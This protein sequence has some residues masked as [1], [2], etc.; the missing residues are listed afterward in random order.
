MSI[1]SDQLRKIWTHAPIDRCATYA[2]LLSDA[3]AKFEIDTPEEIVE[4][5]AQISHE[6]AEGRYT[7]EIA[8]GQAYEGRKDLGNTQPGD[9]VRYKGRGL[10]QCTGRTNYL[11]MG[12]LLDLDLIA[13]PELLEQ[14]Q[15]A[16]LSAA[17]FWWNHKLDNLALKKDFIAVT[18]VINGG[19]N[20]LADRQAYLVLARRVI[21]GAA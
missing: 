13:H 10:I 8:S 1:T 18:K 12:V 20:G 2:P 5:L 14:P 16:C 3:M 19:T 15:Y 6:S 7:L 17:A 4:F 9:G 21:P 11:L